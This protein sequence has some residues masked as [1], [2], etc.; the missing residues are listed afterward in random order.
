V[1]I[2]IE[3]LPPADADEDGGCCDASGAAG[4]NLLAP[5]ALVALAIRRRRRT[6]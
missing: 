4:A 5:L 1:V 6:A 2:T 3:P